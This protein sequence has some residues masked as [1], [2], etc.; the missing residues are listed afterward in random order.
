MPLRV[1]VRY[2]TGAVHQV[3][4]PGRIA[5]LGRDPTCDLVLNDAKCSRRHAVI[6]EDPGGPVIRDTGSANGLFVNGRKISRAVLGPRDEI[7]AGD[8]RLRLL[9]EG[10]STLIVSMQQGLAPVA[11]SPVA[12]TIGEAL[13]AAEVARE[14]DRMEAAGGL[15]GGSG[16]G[17][18]EA[19]RAEAEPPP[20]AT[21]PAGRRELAGE[22]LLQPSRTSAAAEASRKRA[23]PTALVV[24]G[25]VLAFLLAA[26]VVVLAMVVLPRLL[27]SG[28]KAAAEQLRA[29]A[30]AQDAF[31]QVCDSG[32]GD[33]EALLNPS[34]VFPDYPRSGPAFLKDPS[35][36]QPV[37]AG[38][39]FELVVADPAP[40]TP[41][42]PFRSYRRYDYRAV[43]V[44]GKGR[45]LV[46]S[47]DGVVRAAAAP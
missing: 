43:P 29:L 21:P 15:T 12:P 16:A 28:E 34:S 5:I 3:T 23:L 19:P 17:R 10:E 18:V 30:A 44:S 2:P 13:S 7:Q 46:V 14:L 35:F 38:Y 33:L 32:Y 4:L 26:L 27:R 39:R 41:S 24:G 36:R 42:C 6:E 8:L 25:V 20:A 37:R 9:P 45:T 1:E 11:V 31:R 22:I 40:A 47:N